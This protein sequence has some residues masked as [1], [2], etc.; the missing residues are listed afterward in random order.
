MDLSREP[1]CT[2]RRDPVL[3]RLFAGLELLL[4]KRGTIDGVAQTGQHPFVD[5]IALNERTVKPGVVSSPYKNE[6]LPERPVFFAL[7]LLFDGTCYTARPI[8]VY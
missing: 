8:A 3:R 2:K 6:R 1:K 7:N 4:F 5:L